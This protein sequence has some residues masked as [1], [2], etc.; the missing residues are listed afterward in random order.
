MDDVKITDNTEDRLQRGILIYKCGWFRRDK[1]NN[2]RRRSHRRYLLQGKRGH[3][4][5]ATTI[6]KNKN[7][8]IFEEGYFHKHVELE[9]VNGNIDN[10]PTEKIDKEVNKVREKSKEKFINKEETWIAFSICFVIA[11]IVC[12]GTVDD[13]NNLV[14]DEIAVSKQI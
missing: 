3:N 11:L 14:E 9:N 7:I 8:L 4:Q 5:M 13:T 2:D 12:K 1:P 6:F 10:V